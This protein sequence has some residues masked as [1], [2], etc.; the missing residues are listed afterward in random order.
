[1]T[2]GDQLLTL[3]RTAFA[4]GPP[5]RLGVAV[6]GGGD[7]LALLYLL[8]DWRQ[9]DGPA[10]DVVTVNHGLRAE[11]ADEAAMV[12]R[13]A[14]ALGLSHTTLRWDRPAP[15]GNLPHEAR[16]A[17][18]A[19]MADWA[20]GRGIGT[21]ALGHTADDQAETFLM[22]LA[23]GSGVDGLAAMAQHRRH[24]GL[25][26]VRP[27]IWARRVALRDYL[28]ARGLT[29]IEDPTND[30]L[31]YERV[32][33]RQALPLLAPLGITHE[34]LIATASRLSM[35][36]E[37]LGRAAQDLARRAVS[38]QA[39]DLILNCDALQADRKSVV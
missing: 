20:R 39:G 31:A 24:L 17:R 33:A 11:A 21:V 4:P 18:Y 36:R 14:G 8:N 30:D 7:S 28:T 25:T 15:A 16:R 32:R 9:E 34:G 27:L 22:R 35:A 12:A 38:F 29:W 13:V 19:L 1:M 23:R 3:L 10:L 6:S 5:D 37:A 26:W 2:G